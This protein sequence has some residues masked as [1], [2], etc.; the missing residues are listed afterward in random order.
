MGVAVTT[1]AVDVEDPEPSY[2][3]AWWWTLGNWGNLTA[4]V[5]RLKRLVVEAGDRDQECPHD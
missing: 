1:V 2:G 5:D 4:S 3:T